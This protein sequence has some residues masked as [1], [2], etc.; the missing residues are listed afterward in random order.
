MVKD[1]LSIPLFLILFIAAIIY[2]GI[3]LVVESLGVEV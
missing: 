1:I 2:A 3:L